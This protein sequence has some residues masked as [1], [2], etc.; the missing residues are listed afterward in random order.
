MKNR[1]AVGIGVLLIAL[2][3]MMVTATP[4]V[5]AAS[6]TP[7]AD[8]FGLPGAVTTGCAKVQT[9][10]LS[11][12]QNDTLSGTVVSDNPIEIMILNATDY[13]TLQSPLLNC[14]L[15][16]GYGYIITGGVT[17]YS[18]SWMAPYS[19]APYGKSQ[20]ANPFYLIFYNTGPNPA[21]ISVNLS[22]PLSS[23]ITANV[24]A[25]I[26]PTTS[27]TVPLTGA[28]TGSASYTG[29]CVVCTVTGNM[30]VSYN[31][32][33]TGGMIIFGIAYPDGSGAL[34]GT[35]Q[36]T[37]NSCAPL[38]A[39][40]SIYDGDAVCAA[41]PKSNSGSEFVTFNITTTAA[42]TCPQSAM[43]CGTLALVA[44]TSTFQANSGKILPGSSSTSHFS[45]VTE[46]TADV[47]PPSPNN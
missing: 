1:R 44:Y 47:P 7:F 25:Q 16:S 33:P 10:S 42:E 15:Y 3:I 45:F 46:V 40:A 29:S 38:P 43:D 35:I 24:A 31:G 39:S 41:F 12:N 2:A 14:Y 11:M 21:K 9:Y 19:T 36:S 32:L 5:F 18:L 8:A 22:M 4:A 23:S 28:V 17:N 34:T 13:Q 30:T 6:S 37:P 20:D 26:P 27:I